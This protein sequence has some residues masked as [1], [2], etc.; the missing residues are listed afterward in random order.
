MVLLGWLLA[1]GIMRATAQQIIAWGSNS[2]GQTTIPASASNAVAVA[3]GAY[4]SMALRNDGTV[5]TWGE[6]NASAVPANPAG[7]SNIVSIAAGQSHCVALRS[8][9]KVFAW[10]DNSQGQLN[11][12]PAASNVVA[13]AAGY[14]HTLALRA[15]GTVV[16]WGRNTYG[17]VTIPT[18]LTNV[19]AIAA[20]AEQ[21]VALL[22]NNTIVTWGGSPTP[23]Y[24]GGG[25]AAYDPGYTLTGI[26]AWISGN[27]AVRTDGKI[28]AW[29][30]TPGIPANATNVV[31]ISCGTNYSLAL[32]GDGTLVGLVAGTG[33]T[34]PASATN[35]FRIA[36]GNL[37]G[38]AIEGNGAPVIFGPVAFKSHAPLGSLLPLAVRAAGTGALSYQW[39]ANGVPIPGATNAIPSFDAEAGGGSIGYQ[40]VVSNGFGSTTSAIVNVTV[41]SVNVW[42]SDTEHQCDYPPGIGSPVQIAAG[43]FH[44]LALEANGTLIS[45]GKNRSGQTNVPAAATNIIAIAAGQN[46]S[47]ALRSD[48]SV[49]AWGDLTQSSV[50]A[51][52]TNVQ[53]IGAGWEYS[54][55]L[56][57]DGTVIA[58]GNDDYNQTNVPPYLTN[59]TAI[60]AGYYHALALMPNHTVV[61]WG[62]QDLVP[63]EA[64]NVVAIAA[65]YEDSL[66][67]RA[68]GS[69][70]AWGDDSMGQC[71][72]P[73]T[74]TNA[75]AIAAGFGHSL[76]LLV[77]GTVVAWGTNGSV[78]NLPPGLSNI[79]AIAC[80]EDHDFV[81]ANAGAPQVFS[82]SPPIAAHVG[83]TPLLA[84]YV[85]GQYPMT[86]QW[87]QNGQPVPGATNRWFIMPPLNPT[88]A[89]LY[90]LVVNNSA[91]TA[92]SGPIDVT[93]STAPYF[94]PA[95]PAPVN[96]IAGTAL[97]VSA[98]PEGAQPLSLRAQLNGNWLTD[99]AQIFGA[100]TPTICFE[101]TTF[102]DE[103]SLTMV[104]TNN[105]GSYTGLV[106]NL[107]VTP[108]AG[109][110][111]NTAGQLVIPATTSNIVAIA[112]GGDHCLALRTDGTVIAWGDNTYGQ[113]QVPAT[114][115]NVVSIAEGDTD[116]LAIRADGTV[117]AWGDN[118]YGQT[119]VPTTANGAVQVAAGTVMSVAL[120]PG[121]T[122][123]SWNNQNQALSSNPGNV[124]SISARGL[125]ILGLLASGKVIGLTY[126]STAPVLISNV[127][128]IAAG[129][130]HG[131]A[132]LT[133]HNVVTW[134]NNNYGQT[135]IPAAATNIIAIAAGDYSSLALRADGVVFTWGFT[136]YNQVAPPVVP[137]QMIT[138]GSL[139]NL[140]VSSQPISISL[141]NG[142]S[143]LLTAGNLGSGNGAYQ[144]L[145]N[146]TVIPGATRSTLSLANLQWTNSGTYQVVASNA[147]QV[148]FGPAI[149]VIL[150]PPP[151]FQFDTASLAYHPGSGAFQMRLTGSSGTGHVVIYSS[152]NL[153]NWQPIFT[154]APTTNV[155]K[156][157]DTRP[158]G[159]PQM[160]YQ[161]VQLA[162]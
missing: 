64:T 127:T 24:T 156:F 58:W 104:V 143:T 46:H 89:G 159:G 141:T 61:S 108:I 10:G 117:I 111:D 14:Y 160:F 6:I 69:V 32:R 74:V 114:A 80:G 43:A 135:N 21:S 150:P 15:D 132:L 66:A 124:V 122:L 53:S 26:A 136:N 9:G 41:D 50:P 3:A 62:S 123:A 30:N 8:D 98:D 97:C 45:W 93:V 23:P 94:A 59:A 86:Y 155:I 116:S 154:N 112:S 83:D 134:G 76:A 144:W 107:A 13:I 147:L 29:G 31:T 65:G 67:L 33:P 105:Y 82:H 85:S 103:G 44:N 78:S 36:A 131:L 130:L 157:T 27:Y 149:N 162:N 68:D 12:S 113:N 88:N 22:N 34:P 120:M 56:R 70:I 96:V 39:L 138:A 19:A 140:A 109:W 11:I 73:D 25:Y 20:G 119:N 87:C 139:H 35:V 128:A 161:A 152:P 37:H 63:P 125:N 52:V 118:T 18:G 7:V 121:G 100:T 146:G 4:H 55:A 110:G 99:G 49:V 106:A 54:L 2:Y 16:G 101:P 129:S 95:T 48:G 1:G 81:V 72:I 151:P 75:V 42:G 91:G 142:G 158:P 28:Y 77:N 71:E 84:G 17:Q 133:N 102:A 60:A 47:M 92:T 126:L 148:V 79:A 137:V 40:V 38:L 5:I 153:V 57:N 145:F 51:S 115:T 90:T